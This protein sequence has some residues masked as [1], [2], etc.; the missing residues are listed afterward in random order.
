MESKIFWAKV[1]K[2]F[3]QEMGKFFTGFLLLTGLF[4]SL[5]V[6][7]ARYYVL[8]RDASVSFFLDLFIDA[9]IVGVPYFTTLAVINMLRAPYLTG[10]ELQKELEKFEPSKIAIEEYYYNYPTPNRKAGLLIKNLTDEDLDLVI[11]LTEFRVF[12]YND[13]DEPLDMSIPI[14]KDG[15]YFEVPKIKRKS[16]QVIYLAEAEDDKVTILTK[17]PFPMFYEFF[18]KR[19]PGQPERDF[20]KLWI[21]PTFAFRGKFK[22]N[23]FND[24]YACSMTLRAFKPSLPRNQYIEIDEIAYMPEESDKQKEVQSD[25]ANQ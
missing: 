4:Y 2:K 11:E 9:I 15:C 22:K 24:R 18:F 14:D 7:L 1:S 13:F 21:I 16:H 19:Q 20:F 17:K 5:T 10:I 23:S 8:G 3:K 12:E 6:G 25:E